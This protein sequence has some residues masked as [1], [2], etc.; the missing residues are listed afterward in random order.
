MRLIKWE[1]PTSYGVNGAVCTYWYALRAAPQL[2][3]Q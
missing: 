2:R 1:V 3:V